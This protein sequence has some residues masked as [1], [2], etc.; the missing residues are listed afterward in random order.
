M[1]RWMHEPADNR[2]QREQDD[3]ADRGDPAP[4]ALFRGFP[5]AARAC[6]R[7]HEQ[8]GR[9]DARDDCARERDDVRKGAHLTATVVAPGRSVCGHRDDGHETEGNQAPR[10]RVPAH[11]RVG[12]GIDGHAHSLPGDGD[13]RRPSGPERV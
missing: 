9:Q 4:P 12:G 8:Q 2:D 5:S 1:I 3:E 11:D 13:P 7:E 6:E 10:D